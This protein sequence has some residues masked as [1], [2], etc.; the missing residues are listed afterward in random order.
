MTLTLAAHQLALPEVTDFFL[1]CICQSC[2]S[3]CPMVCC[4]FRPL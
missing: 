1:G 4:I 3:T 2:K